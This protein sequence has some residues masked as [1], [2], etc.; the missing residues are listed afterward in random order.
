MSRAGLQN[1]LQ[2]LTF[3]DMKVSEK[4]DYDNSNWFIKTGQTK[5]VSMP[6][7]PAPSFSGSPQKSKAQLLQELK[8]VQEQL[9][10]ATKTINNAEIAEDEIMANNRHGS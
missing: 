7:G 4:S 1:M 5:S 3:N 2:G 6:R 8:D 9:D 10:R